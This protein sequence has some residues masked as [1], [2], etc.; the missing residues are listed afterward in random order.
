[1][2][3]YILTEEYSFGGDDSVSFEVL[4]AYKSEEQAIKAMNHQHEN[5][6]KL[7]PWK[8]YTKDDIYIEETN[9][10]IYILDETDAEHYYLLKVE[11]IVLQD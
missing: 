1:M 10:S 6:M 11:P 4:G 2:N 5:N 7:S 8:L 9:T 3:F